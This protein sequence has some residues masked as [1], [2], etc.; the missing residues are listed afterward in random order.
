MT[1]AA[2]PKR[3]TA[4]KRAGQL[5]REA[6]EILDAGKALDITRIDV[7]G[8][9]TITDHMLIATANSRIHARALAERLVER[10]KERS[11]AITGV[12]GLPAAEWVLVDLGSVV[13]HIMLA[14]VRA[15]YDLEELWS[16][17]PAPAGD[18][19]ENPTESEA[20]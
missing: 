11:R 19:A 20:S 14:Q 16:F 15:L 1:A 6:G 17:E 2:D 13:V 7:R 12:E 18:Q 8:L 3:R 4:G 9:T 5:A 10:M